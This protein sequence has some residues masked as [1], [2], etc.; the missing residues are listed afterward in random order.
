[1]KKGFMKRTLMLL[2][3][4]IMIVSAAACSKEAGDNETG[5]VSNDTS[6][7]S[8]SSTDAGASTG[9]E[10]ISADSPYKDMGFDLSKTEEVVMYVVGERPQD[11]DM[12]LDKL[13]T[14]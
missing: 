11:M 6:S 1:M 2:M 12:V 8:G 14:E 10:G 4:M 13:N 9:N 3:A 5:K 7:T